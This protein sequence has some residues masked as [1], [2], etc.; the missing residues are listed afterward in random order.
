MK[1]ALE[2][3]GII[4]RLDYVMAL[5]VNAIWTSPI[6]RSPMADFDYAVA[7]YCYVD[8]ILSVRFGERSL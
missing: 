5:G 4:R 7:D 8:Q 2:T 1:A 3:Y 6:Y